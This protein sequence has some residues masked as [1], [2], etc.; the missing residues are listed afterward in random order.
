M[1]SG[2][3][4]LSI[5]IEGVYIHPVCGV[6]EVAI[7]ESLSCPVQSRFLSLRLSDPNARN[8]AV[9]RSPSRGAPRPD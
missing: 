9:E 2:D 3:F 7:H 1:T 4:S 6:V 5:I 8:P